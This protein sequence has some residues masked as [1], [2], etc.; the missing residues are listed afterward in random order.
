MMAMR[1]ANVCG[2]KIYVIIGTSAAFQTV[3]SAP[4]LLSGQWRVEKRK[5]NPLNRV[6]STSGNCNFRPPPPP[7]LFRKIQI[8]PPH[9]GSFC[10]FDS[11]PADMF[12]PSIVVSSETEKKKTRFDSTE[13]CNPGKKKQVAAA[14]S[15]G[16]NSLTE[17]RLFETVNGIRS[18]LD[19]N[20][21]CCFF[22][23]LFS[24]GFEICVFFCCCFCFPNGV[25]IRNQNERG[26]TL[27]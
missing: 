25:G 15:H 14:P 27:L 24:F 8:H 4:H 1:D 23:V 10:F 21:C 17:L 18:H 20:D 19:V 9:R 12:T 16:G 22:S 13:W 5:K 2:E 6:W 3:E 11:T 26:R 7:Q